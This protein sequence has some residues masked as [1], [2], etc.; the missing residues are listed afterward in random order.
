MNR[1]I[2]VAI[3][4]CGRISKKHIEAITSN[5][6]KFDLSA[7]CDEDKIKLDKKKY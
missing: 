3:L 4:G 7:L 5:K 2:K 6:S 1:K